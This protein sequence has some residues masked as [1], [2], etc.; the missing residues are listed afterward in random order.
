M[1]F[2]DDLIDA[3]LA[4]KAAKSTALINAKREAELRINQA[5]E[6]RDILAARLVDEQGLPVD[7][8]REALGTT[9]YATAKAAVAA[10]R[11]ALDR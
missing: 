2:L 4:F 1:T 3:N 5:R 6:R 9:N 10:G 8:V 11:K 7:R